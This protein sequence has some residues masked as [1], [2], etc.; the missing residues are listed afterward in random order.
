M[1]KFIRIIKSSD[2]ELE[3][4]AA[5]EEF[6][7]L[8]EKIVD[9]EVD[10]KAGEY[11]E[12]KF[13]KIKENIQKSTTLQELADASMFATIDDLLNVYEEESGKRTDDLDIL[14][15]FCINRFD[16]DYD[17]FEWYKEE[18]IKNIRYDVENEIWSNLEKYPK[19]YK[20]KQIMDKYEDTYK[21]IKEE[22]YDKIEEMARE[23]AR[24]MGYRCSNTKFSN[25]SYS[26]YVTLF[27]DDKMYKI[28]ISD[29][30]DVSMFGPKNSD[31]TLYPNDSLEDNKY[32]LLEIL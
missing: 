8:L 6:S 7:D 29:H 15:K 21:S 10:Q 3:Y 13:D 28:R 27:K 22:P 1:S 5:A 19:L 23:V 30:D 2:I 11:V 14:K 31:I 16:D 32:K 18:N 17:L 9:K 25:S 26:R 20:Y 24:E 12:E 4:T